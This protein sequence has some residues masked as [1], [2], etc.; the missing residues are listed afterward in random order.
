MIRITSCRIVT[1]LAICLGSVAMGSVTLAAPPE[2][3]SLLTAAEIEQVVGKLKETPRVENLGDTAQ[4]IYEF[5]NATSE[6]DIWLGTA[7]SLAP[8]RKRAKQPV[9]VNGI[10]DEALLDRGRIDAST[11][12]LHIRKGKQVLL[13]MLSDTPGDEAKLKA[14]AQKPVGRFWYLNLRPILTRDRERAC[15]GPRKPASLGRMRRH[16]GTTRFPIGA[17]SR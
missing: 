7:D 5:A 12:E 9:A 13:L 6:L 16:N 4:C 15:D 17:P 11:A 10:G 2:P 14:L 8:A 3:C 1:T